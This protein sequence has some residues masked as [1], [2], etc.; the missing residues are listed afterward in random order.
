MVVIPK[1]VNHCRILEN[2][3]LFDF[4]LSDEEMKVLDGFGR[5][6]GR[7]IVPMVNGKARDGHHPH[8]P[9]NIEF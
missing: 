3:D 7:V 9:F 1:S 5:P 8:Y 4:T 2:G 6:N